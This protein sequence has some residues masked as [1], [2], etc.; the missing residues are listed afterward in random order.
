MS[1]VVSTADIA[2]QAQKQTVRRTRRTC[3]EAT[4][5]GRFQLVAEREE[6]ELINGQLVG[7]PRPCSPVV[8]GHDELVSHP[9]FAAVQTVISAAIDAKEQAIE[10]A[11]S[12]NEDA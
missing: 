6:V 2:P 10:Q 5:A 3:I 1:R 7:A 4:A 8:L 11:K 12:A 9:N